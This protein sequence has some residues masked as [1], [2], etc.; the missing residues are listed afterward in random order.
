MAPLLKVWYFTVF[1]SF[2]PF[3]YI[4]IVKET[5]TAKYELML[6]ERTPRFY[7]FPVL[8]AMSHANIFIIVMHGV[9]NM[10]YSLL[11][12]DLVSFYAKLMKYK[13]LYFILR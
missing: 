7:L 9:M 3:G 12:P 10:N 8:Y 4:R 1:E 11:M 13:I 2:Q 5:S 6:F